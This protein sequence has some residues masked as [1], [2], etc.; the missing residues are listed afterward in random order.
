MNLGTTIAQLRKSKKISQEDLASMCN[1]TQAYLSLIEN[2]KKDP[3][4][5]TLKSISDALEVPLPV[6]FFM[7]LETS[8]IRN[9]K[10]KDYEILKPSMDGMIDQIFL[11]DKL[12]HH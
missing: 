11:N 4:L 6:V 7:S 5:T 1:I 12:A 3:H 2:N 9:E 10:L 8:D